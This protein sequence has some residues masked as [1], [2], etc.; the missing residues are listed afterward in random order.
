PKTNQRVGSAAHVRPS[1]RTDSKLFLSLIEGGTKAQNAHTKSETPSTSSSFGSSGGSE[2]QLT[3]FDMLAL[4]GSIDNADQTVD[5]VEN[6]SAADEAEPSISV[7]PFPPLSSRK[8]SP[9]I[10]SPFEPSPEAEDQ[11]TFFDMLALGG[12]IDI[13]YQTCD[14]VENRSAA[15]EAK[16]S[17]SVEPVPTL[18]SQRSVKVNRSTQKPTPRPVQHRV[19]ALASRVTSS[20][21][22]WGKAVARSFVRRPEGNTPSD[23]STDPCQEFFPS[24]GPSTD[25]IGLNDA[26]A[27]PKSNVW[28]ISVTD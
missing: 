8:P 3:F 14:G 1:K 20:L 12:S 24:R 13:A 23:T 27:L 28:N 19:R 25:C 11:L 26:L 7:E 6:T 9:S 4:G 18:L 16:P 10:S 2:D 21:R 5:E 22:Q 15:D 17:F